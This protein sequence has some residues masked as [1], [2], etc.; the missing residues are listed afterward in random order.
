MVATTLHFGVTR[1]DPVTGRR[2]R[3]VAV[4]TEWIFLV[5]FVGGLAW[6]PFLFGSNAPI[7]WGI[8]AVIFGALAAL[9]ELSLVLRGAPH[10]VPIRRIGASAVLL[11]LV[12]IWILVQNVTW[13]PTSW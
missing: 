3:T 9:Y 1:D 5:L 11:A 2:R 4:T 12:T 13:T 10:P 6:I 7:A 8:N